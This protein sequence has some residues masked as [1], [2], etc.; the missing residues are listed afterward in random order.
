MSKKDINFKI[1]DIKNAFNKKNF[2]DVID[3][4]EN[5]SNFKDRNPELSCLLG[6]CKIL[7]PNSKKKEIFSALKDFENGYSKAKKNNIGLDSLCN[8]ISTC[9]LFSKRYPELIDY[10]SNVRSTYTEAENFFGY[11]EKLS[12]AGVKLFKFTLDYD[13]MRNINSN[14]IVNNTKHLTTLCRWA[15]INNYSYTWNQN[16]YF[17]FSNHLKKAFPLYKTKNVDD[18]YFNNERKTK[19]G[20]VSCNYNLGHSIT[21]FMKNIVGN[22]DKKKFET[23]AFDLGKYNED[24]EPD[25]DFIAKFDYWHSLKDQSNQDVI[26]FIQKNKIEILIDVM[27]ITHPDRIGIF[28]NR[29]SPLQI[30]WLAYCNTVGFDKIDYLIA[31][32]NLIKDG[33]DEY[34]GEKIIKLPCI[35]SSHAGFNLRRKYQ[36]LPSKKNKY[37]TFGSFNNFM[38]ISNEVVETWSNILKKVNNSKLI[39]KSSEKYNCEILLKKFKKFG[40]NNMI[41]ILEKNN[42]KKIEDHLSLY[43][44]IDIALDTFPYTGVTTTFE[45][46]WMGVPVITLKGHNFKSRCGESILKNADLKNLICLNRNQYI[47]KAYNLS[48]DLKYLSKVRKDIF[49]NILRTNLFN[50]KKY[51]SEFEKF[52][53]NK[54]KNIN[55]L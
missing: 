52:L 46:L 33:E 23:H 29:V 38:K 3:K 34:Y 18:L 14:L 26:N 12:I 50:N 37:I 1:N 44:D 22:I 10:L 51:T 6:V 25:K 19:I 41:E 15:F 53:L 31:D 7:K 8:Y 24:N 2:D 39:L 43:N 9:I 54:Y 5:L 42:F 47:Q 27:S 13:K 11:N 45:A 40:V 16:D 20:F 32:K 21:Y 4:I 35:W 49:D 55:K 17:N 30:S 36:D 28:N 48:S